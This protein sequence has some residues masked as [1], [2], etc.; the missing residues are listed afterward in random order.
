MFFCFSSIRRHTSCALVT[1][2][3]TCALPIFLYL[4]PRGDSGAHGWRTEMSRSTLSRIRLAA[5]VVLSAAAVAG[6]ADAT[7]TIAYSYDSHGR[8]V[9]VVPTCTVNNHVQVSYT[10]EDADRTEGRRVGQGGGSTD[11]LRGGADPKK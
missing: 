6:I 2:V 4:F 11:K 10:T 5:L 7:A 3:Q 9:K 1:G 8:P